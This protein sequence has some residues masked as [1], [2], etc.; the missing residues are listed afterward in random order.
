[1]PVAMKSTGITSSAVSSPI[2]TFRCP[3]STRYMSG[4]VVLKPSFQPGNG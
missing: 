3:L 4:A 2:G 1:M